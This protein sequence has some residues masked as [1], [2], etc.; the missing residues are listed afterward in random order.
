MPAYTSKFGP[1]LKPAPHLFGFT[2]RAAAPYALALGGFGA[3]AGFAAI[4]FLEGIPRVQQDILQKVPV[5]G[6][7]WTGR[8]IPASDNPF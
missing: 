6:K 2:A 3:V 8:E 7:Y 4:Y 1:K 5:I